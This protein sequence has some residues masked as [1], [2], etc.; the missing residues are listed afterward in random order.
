M[1]DKRYLDGT[2]GNADNVRYV[3]FSGNLDKNGVPVANS[4]NP[5]EQSSRP[6]FGDN[7]DFAE[8]YNSGYPYHGGVSYGGDLGTVG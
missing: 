2:D 7:Y 3:N 8:N 5:N 1:T 4:L 6:A